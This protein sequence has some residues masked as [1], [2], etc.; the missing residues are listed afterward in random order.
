MASSSANSNPFDCL[1]GLESMPGDTPSSSPDNP[2]PEP[3]AAKPPPSD[4]VND[5]PSTNPGSPS[6]DESRS[7][8][9]SRPDRE[10]EPRL[11][12]GKGKDIEADDLIPTTEDSSSDSNICTLDC[13]CLKR[14]DKLEDDVSSIE[15]T[16]TWILDA[17]ADADIHPRGQSAARRERTL[18]TPFF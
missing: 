10:E 2:S 12:K 14:I 16:L 15:D 9:D 11:W 1:Q 7:P 13:H 6:R 4:Q 5:A 8:P 17:L 18:G 3:T